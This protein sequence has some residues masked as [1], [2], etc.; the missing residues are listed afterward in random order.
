[1]KTKRTFI[2]TAAGYDFLISF[3]KAVPGALLCLP[4]LSFCFLFSASDVLFSYRKDSYSMFFSTS[5]ASVLTFTQ[6]ALMAIGL[7][8]ALLLFR[9]L[10][11]V[12]QTNVLLSSGISRQRLFLNR[13]FAGVSALSLG[14]F[15]PLTATLCLNVFVYGAQ[16]Y[17]VKPFLLILL[18]TL[19][20]VLIGF[21]A[22]LLGAV[23]AGSTVE[24]AA[25][26][27]VL[28]SFPFVVLGFVNYCCCIFLKG[29]PPMLN[30]PYSVIYP[31]TYFFSP[32]HLLSTP[33]QMMYP[34]EPMDFV[35]KDSIWGTISYL[36][37]K[38]AAQQIAPDVSLNIP[39]WLLVVFAA[40]IA[41]LC[42]VVLSAYFL[43]LKRKA[44][45]NSRPFRSKG[46]AVLASSFVVLIAAWLCLYI[47]LA[48][49]ADIY[50]FSYYSGSS[51]IKAL[52]WLSL[53]LPAA[54]VLLICLVLYAKIL[55]RPRTLLKALPLSL[56]LLAVPLTCV[57]GGFGYA[58]RIPKAA[59]IESVGLNGVMLPGA[60]NSLVC[61]VQCFES[62]G[63]K[64]RVIDIHEKTVSRGKVY[65][66]SFDISYALKDG[67]ELSRTY[68]ACN[69]DALI[70]IGGLF[71]SD[72]LR[73][74]LYNQIGDKSTWYTDEEQSALNE[75]DALIEP[76]PQETE[77]LRF[78]G[79]SLSLRAGSLAANSVTLDK[80]LNEES[81]DRLL[82]R[83]ANDLTHLSAAA[84]LTPS[85][86][87]VY[88]LTFTMEDTSSEPVEDM[89]PHIDATD[90]DDTPRYKLFVTA[91]M[92]R[93]LKFLTDLGVTESLS[94]NT[95]KEIR[96]YECG[97]TG[98]LESERQLTDYYTDERPDKH[99]RTVTD[100]A[101]IKEM[102]AKLYPYYLSDGQN[103]QYS[104]VVYTDG[105]S[106]YY[107]LKT[108]G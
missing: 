38:D 83:Y 107:L 77:W 3:M 102:T 27:F 18:S 57:F 60:L 25:V 105:S 7:L 11:S 52:Y 76:Y 108:D 5:A 81:F 67:S 98:V 51:G 49:T 95:V 1:M 26:S 34:T 39:S 40:W 86:P 71:E 65:R 9:F 63:D 37:A 92:K 22:G 64:Q 24:A 85:Q 93:T 30:W 106:E 6:Y 50:D 101:E 17:M 66:A 69:S 88:V 87:P 55:K 19:V 28:P 48:H 32:W 13:V 53:F 36:S 14:V 10:G 47:F 61:N 16:S 70:A 31:K 42:L 82:E 45:R 58:G 20:L 12:P 41:A 23:L 99:I 84:F 73:T 62:D 80:R 44:E 75:T 104:C 91:D 46:I 90:T 78:G 2:K 72:V 103:V 97:N 94:Q 74:Y 79:A 15:L 8:T 29:Y 100:P 4:F 56:L 59:D 54:F 33:V 68:F 96:L 21:C 89:N 35:F 43:F